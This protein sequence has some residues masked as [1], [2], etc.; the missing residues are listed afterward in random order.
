MQTTKIK[1]TKAKALE[2]MDYY[3]A[4]EID[5]PARPYDF[6]EVED[7]KDG[8]VIKGYKTK[9]PDVFT[10]TF[11]GGESKT[12]LEASIFVP[13]TQI[14]VS[15]P[16]G[17]EDTG[18]Q[19]GSD[20]VGVG[21]FFGPMIVT[22]S[23]FLPSQMS[24]LERLDVRDSKKLT[25]AHIFQIG[26]V[27]RAKIKHHTV[28]CSANKL[29]SYVAKGFSTHWVLAH[30]HNLAQ[31]KLI[32]KYRLSEDIVV[33]VDQ[34]EREQLYRKYV[35]EALIS[36]PLIFRPRGESRWPSVA[37]SSVLSRY[38]FLLYWEKMEKTLGHVLPK[39]AGAEVDK[40]YKKII[41]D[42]GKSNVDKYVKK[43][44]RNYRDLAQ[45]MIDDRKE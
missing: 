38:E 24:L 19:I 23:Y 21:D 20:E 14:Q 29:S 15:S 25:D 27:L 4:K 8:L 17:F 2:I 42:V 12:S 45:P 22:A 3:H 32:E 18:E 11:M 10:I 39:G 44:F 37:I 31:Q 16:Q 36:N 41:E 34:F 33:Y 35:G 7:E 40:V 28:S 26:H 5:D 9:N 13:T 1:V 6:F 43:F 30:L